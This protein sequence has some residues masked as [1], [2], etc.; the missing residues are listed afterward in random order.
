MKHKL[1]VTLAALAA[2]LPGHISARDFTYT[3]EGQTI[4]YTVLDE[5][6]KTC[7]TKAGISNATTIPGNNIS[8]NLIL[9]ANPKD[10]NVEYNLTVISE[11]A[12]FGCNNLTS[13]IIPNSV[14]D[15][16]DAAF[17]DCSSLTSIDIP[18]SVTTINW[19][20][21]GR[22]AITEISIPNSVTSIGVGAFY[23]CSNLVSI[24]IPDSVSFI[25]SSAFYGCNNLTKAEF[26][27]I[28]ALCEIE[29]DDYYANPLQFAHHLYID[30]EK[31]TDVTIP[32]SVTSIGDCTFSGCSSI[33]SIEIPKSVT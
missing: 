16:G 14:K 6:Y 31:I 2:L 4:T 12:F 15:I 17:G 11:Y 24:K 9:P 32:N 21:F 7:Q 22:T 19:S 8:G 3:Y 28:K 13:V 26:A 30:G 1:L 20:A 29:F 18:N 33:K 10:G 25:G 5:E 27:S 23:E